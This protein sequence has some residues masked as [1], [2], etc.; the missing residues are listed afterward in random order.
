MV[1]GRV[2]HLGIA[3]YEAT[4]LKK[5]AISP[6][7]FDRPYVSKPFGT[8]IVIDRIGG[9]SDAPEAYFT[10]DDRFFGRLHCVETVRKVW[11][12][13]IED[14]PHPLDLRKIEAQAS[15]C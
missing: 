9:N 5:W 15:Y 8:N 13:E 4:I 10:T 3:E 6:P 2:A 1:D 12:F 7:D 14:M 11:G